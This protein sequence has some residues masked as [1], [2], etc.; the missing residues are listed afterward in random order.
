MA[1]AQILSVIELDQ[2]ICSGRPRDGE[3]TY[4]LFDDRVPHPKRLDAT[5]RSPRSSS[6]T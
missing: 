3:H 1:A 5:R 4:A 6:A 2:L